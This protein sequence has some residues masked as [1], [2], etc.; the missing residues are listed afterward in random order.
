M[1]VKKEMFARCLLIDV[2]CIRCNHYKSPN[3]LCSFSLHLGQRCIARR[4]RYSNT[5]LTSLLRCTSQYNPLKCTA[6]YSAPHSEHIHLHCM[7]SKAPTPQLHSKMHQDCSFADPTVVHCSTLQSEHLHLH[8]CAQHK[9][10]I[11]LQNPP[12]R[13][14]FL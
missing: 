4:Q 9:H 8:I 6:F 1:K 5:A 13:L 14:Q 2:V 12:R 7:H 3:L 11:S 10:P